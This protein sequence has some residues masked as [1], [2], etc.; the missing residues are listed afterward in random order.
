MISFRKIS[1][2]DLL[3]ILGWRTNPEVTRYMST[4]IEYNLEKQINWYEQVVCAKSP[5]EHWIIV[6]NDKPVGLLNIENR[7]LELQQASW[8]YYIG[9]LDSLIIGGLI[10]AYFYNYMFFHRDLMI[11]KIN[12]HLF[13]LNTK[14]LKIHRFYGVKEVKLLERHVCKYGEMFDIILIE[15]TREMWLSRKEDFQNYWAN[16]EE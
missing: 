13:S 14:V 7:D 11:K 3:M 6:H 15:M 12:G 16:F 5:T 4:D 10:P 9:E 2:N 8:S 1:E